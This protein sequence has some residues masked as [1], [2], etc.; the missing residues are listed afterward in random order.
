MSPAQ[1]PTSTHA[2]SVAS[3]PTTRSLPVSP[4]RP[5]RGRTVASPAVARDFDPTRRTARAAL[6]VLLASRLVA[7]EDNLTYLAPEAYEP[8]PPATLSCVPDLDGVI[9]ADEL[10]PA[11]DVP[12]S[13]LVSAAGVARPVD[14]VGRVAADGRREWDLSSPDTDPVISVTARPIGAHWAAASFPADAFTAPLD[15]GHSLEGI[16]RHDGAELTLLGIASRLA[17]PPEGRTLWRYESPIAL[18]RFPLTD[19]QRWVAVSDI[20][21]G[22]VRGLPYAG[23]DT[24]DIEVSGAGRVLLPDLTFTQALRV[25]TRLVAQPAVGASQS[26]QQVS[27]L[28]ECFGEVARFTSE[29]NESSPDFTR[30]SEVRRLGL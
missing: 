25:R 5:A 16:Y 4:R 10:M 11:L 27:F 20:R 23:R 28:F 9:G 15:A 12:V 6:C 14:P 2:L 22:L 21:N 19:G 29:P 13:Y 30:A 3:R 26:R 24:Y 1:T 18:Y 7:C 8:P 17:D